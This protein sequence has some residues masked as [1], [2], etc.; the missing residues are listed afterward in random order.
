MSARF[1]ADPRMRAL[2]AYLI[3]D[4]KMHMSEHAL[5]RI[6]LAVDLAGWFSLGEI[7]VPLGRP[8]LATDGH[9]LRRC[10]VGVDGKILMLAVNGRP[11]ESAPFRG[12][13]HWRE[14]PELPR[15]T[16]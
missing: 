12:V 15:G 13:T 10:A 9:L 14:E 2:D 8:F 7:P 1:L 6:A 11:V 5:A 4:L 3:A 16:Q